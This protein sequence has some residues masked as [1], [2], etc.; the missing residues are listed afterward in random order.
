MGIKLWETDPDAKP[1]S[2][3]TD[4]IVGRWRSGD[5][6]NDKPV[7][8]TEWKF[9]TDSEEAAHR[10]AELYGG[11]VEHD[12]DNDKAPFAVYTETN[13]LR[14][15]LSKT[16]ISSSMVLWG[17][18]KMIRS[19][20]GVT[21][22]KPKAGEPCQC[23][24]KLALRKEAANEG[25]GCTPSVWVYV[26]LADAPELGRQNYS[27][28]SWGFAVGDA[29]KMEAILETLGDDETIEADFTIEQVTTAAGRTF[30]MPTLKV[31]K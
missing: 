23:P 18:S 14:V 11:T 6:L 1:K 13:T 24:P 20:D 27:T 9:T 30:S 10:I 7:S 19:C 28:G 29:P 5:Y 15:I 16:A 25:W 12:D 8:L 21:Q 2:Y 22:K 26:T 4:D 17:K 31:A 3:N